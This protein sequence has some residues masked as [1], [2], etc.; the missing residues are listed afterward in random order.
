MSR[1]FCYTRTP[2]TVTK[3]AVKKLRLKPGDAIVA[4]ELADIEALKAL[5]DTVAFDVPIIFAPNG[6]KRLGLKY[7]QQLVTRMEYAQAG[8]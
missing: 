7:L 3:R 8:K 1:M 5:K 6:L 2:S 4:H